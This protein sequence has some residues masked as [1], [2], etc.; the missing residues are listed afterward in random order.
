[1]QEVA[2]AAAAT[3]AGDGEDSAQRIPRTNGRT[4]GKRKSGGKDD[5]RG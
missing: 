1:M 5:D 4:L 2:A 3:T